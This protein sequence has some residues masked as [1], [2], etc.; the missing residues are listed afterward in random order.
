ML[1]AEPGTSL[2]IRQ[3]Y[4]RQIAV[5]VPQE[6]DVRSGTNVTALVLFKLHAGTEVRV[7]DRREEALRIALPEEGRGGWIEAQHAEL[8]I[9]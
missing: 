2:A 9:E 6:V 8:V 5:I 3:F 1:H 7:V 4:P